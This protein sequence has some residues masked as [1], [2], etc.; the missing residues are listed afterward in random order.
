MEIINHDIMQV[1]KNMKNIVQQAG[2]LESQLSALLPALPKP[3][4][5]LP[6]ETE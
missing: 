3:N 1:E 6:M 5:T 4:L 2:P